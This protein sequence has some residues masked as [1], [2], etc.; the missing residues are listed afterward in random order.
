MKK[1]GNKGFVLAET[2]IVTVFLMVLF[3]MIYSNFYPL[4]G[5]YEKRENYDDVDGKYTA[6]WIKKMIES[7]GYVLKAADGTCNESCQKRMYSM[8]NWGYMRFECKDMKTDNNQQ[9]MCKSL[10][11]AL[12]ISNCDSSGN[13]CD[14]Y[15]TRYTIDYKDAGKY[16]LKEQL[17]TKSIKHWNEAC[18]STTNATTASR[19]NSSCASK[20]FQECCRQKGLSTCTRPILSNNVTDYSSTYTGDQTAEHDSIAKFCNTRLMR[21]AFPSPAKDY[22]LSLPNYSINHTTTGA[23]YRVIVVVQHK[24]DNN[25]YYSFSTMEVI[26]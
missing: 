11:N 15:I 22:I 8:N 14:I 20:A 26:K 9:E 12:E 23:K 13:G 18:T 24:K 17:R 19:Y 1:I 3:T 25:N 7:D 5:E 21:K 10:V 6:Y 2:L 16:N 4:I